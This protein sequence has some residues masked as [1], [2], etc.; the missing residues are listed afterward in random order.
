MQSARYLAL[1]VASARTSDEFYR[2]LTQGNQKRP[3]SDSHS[4]HMDL[5][6]NYRRALD[7]EIEYLRS[8]AD[9]SPENTES[10]E[11]AEAALTILKGDM[12]SIESGVPPPPRQRAC[13]GNT[14]I[15]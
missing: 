14:V 8:T 5:G 2:C 1:A 12:E 3:F 13:N 6:G 15:F 4:T 11:I 10:L 7:A 9:E